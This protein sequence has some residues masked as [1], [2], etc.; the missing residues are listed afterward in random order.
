MRIRCSMRKRLQFV[1]AAS[2]IVASAYGS[3]GEPIDEPDNGGKL[4]HETCEFGA[5]IARNIPS[6]VLPAHQ[7]PSDP[8][9]P[10]Q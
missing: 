10:S 7:P 8:A 5:I 4:I 6:F 1:A 2:W 9:P 3:P